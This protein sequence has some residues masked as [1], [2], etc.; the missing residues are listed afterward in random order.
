[1]GMMN[2]GERKKSD[3]TAKQFTLNLPAPL[4]HLN[5]AGS[6][7]LRGSKKIMVHSDNAIAPADTKGCPCPL[8]LVMKNE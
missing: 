6:L 2:G 5:S 1:M 8:P 4:A 7:P 3:Q